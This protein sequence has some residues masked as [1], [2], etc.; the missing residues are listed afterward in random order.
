VGA[1]A[2]DRA[3]VARRINGDAL[4][5]CPEYAYAEAVG[6]EW[7]P[8]LYE[9]FKN[10]L[11]PGMT[12]LD[13][14]AS[15]GLYAIAAARAVGMSGRVFAF[16]PAPR[17]ARALRRHLDYNDAAG[18]VEVIEAAVA[19]RT[20]HASFWE[21]ETSFVASLVE[22]SARREEGRYGAPLVP[23]RVR[24]VALDDFCADRSVE[25]DVVKIDVE[26][27][28]AG[29]LRGARRLLRRRHSTVFL[30]VHSEPAPSED[31]AAALTELALAG[32]T[33]EQVGAE[34]AATHYFC[35]P[36]R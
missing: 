17:S 13:V 6:S 22:A 23:R 3:R 29:V 12:V 15:F 31:P 24:A 26:G 35:C 10:A 30:E 19:D 32:W 27:A 11:A 18:T 8:A 2:G 9:R 34:A 28:E 33:C 25:P 1:A 20:G 5:L 36:G 4:L 7:E 21:Q 14:G 16:E